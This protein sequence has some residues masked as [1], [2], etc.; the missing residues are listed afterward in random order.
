MTQVLH[1]DDVLS[2]ISIAI[3]TGWAEAHVQRAEVSDQG[4]RSHLTQQLR[5]DAGCRSGERLGGHA[6]DETA[7]GENHQRRGEAGRPAHRAFGVR[8]RPF[9]HRA[10]GHRSGDP[11]HGLGRRLVGWKR[12]QC[13]VQRTLAIQYPLARLASGDVGGEPET[14]RGHDVIVAFAPD[15]AGLGGLVSRLEPFLDWAGGLW[16]SW[17][18]RSSPLASDIIESD[19]RASG[20]S[21]GLVDNKI[22]AIDEDWSGLRFVHRKEN[23]PK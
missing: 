14:P 7:D 23:R 9:A 1:L 16:I 4:D 18:K 5:C 21:V 19:V 22:C 13:V 3:C 10:G 11:T 2:Q 17:P 8:A 12:R 20:L 15:L 6:H